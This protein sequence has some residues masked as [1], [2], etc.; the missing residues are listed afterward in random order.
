MGSARPGAGEVFGTGEE[1]ED[2][3]VRQHIPIKHNNSNAALLKVDC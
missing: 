2:K 3:L 1:N